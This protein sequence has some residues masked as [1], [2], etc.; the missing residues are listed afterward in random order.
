[1]FLTLEQGMVPCLSLFLWARKTKD[2]EEREVERI[3]VLQASNDG[4]LLMKQPMCVTV[5]M[6]TQIQQFQ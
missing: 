2:S 6:L 1:M 5:C 3:A 4:Y